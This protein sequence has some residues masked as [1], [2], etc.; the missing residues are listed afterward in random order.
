MGKFLIKIV[1]LICLLAL[2]LFGVNGIYVKNNPNAFL[3]MTA[4]SDISQLDKFLE[5][6][7]KL[8]VSNVGS[9]HG[10]RGFNYSELN[11]KGIG[12]MNFGL[13]AQLPSYDYRILQQYRDNLQEGGIVF[14]PISYFSY[15]LDEA[16]APDF[17]SKNFRY[18]Y[19]LKAK[20]IKDFSLKYAA[21][22]KFPIL[23][24]ED[25]LFASFDQVE[26]TGAP[27]APVAPEAPEDLAIRDGHY[28]A[29]SHAEQAGMKILDEEVEAVEGM[30]RLVK[31]EG[32][33]P[34]LVTVPYLDEYNRFVPPELE[35]L[36]KDK[37]N[38]I[39]KKFDVGYYDYSR[40]SRFLGRYEL[41]S[42]ANHL[43][44]EGQIY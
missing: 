28:A 6:G 26:E 17:Q 35:T 13:S 5:V 3:E 23:G 22:E 1:A 9:S 36:V 41:F 40:D 8:L 39:A 4:E 2:I 25:K 12:T 43:S 16:K 29:N 19:F 32:L 11:E 7:D 27:A 14:I 38:E 18:Y 44:T 34:V 30:I 37:T 15:G 42:G 20:Y 31:E 21:I 10:Q 33:T 24:A